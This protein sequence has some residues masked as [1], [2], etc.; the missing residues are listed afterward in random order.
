[1]SNFFD[2]VTKDAKALE[3]KL[4]GP[5]YP[6]Y[7]YVA[8]PKQVGITPEGSLSATATD[9]AGL[10]NY[11]E[12]L[13]TGKGKA[14]TGGGEP[15]GDK[16]FLK[17]GGQ[18]KDI[19]SGKLVDRYLY[20]NNQPD[21]SVPFITSGAG[22]QFTDFE[23]LVPGIIEDLDAMNPISIFRGFMEGNNPPCTEITMPTKTAKNVLGSSSFHVSNGDIQDLGPCDFPSKTNPVTK[24]SCKEAFVGSA[25]DKKDFKSI[26]IFLFGIVMLFIVQRLL[27]RN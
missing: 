2:E 25:L 4:L 12:L 10:I 14:N 6:Y 17:T 11:V 15:L 5:D 22:V 27:K 18:C 9:I 26:Y 1:M 20:I 21:G 23:G 19:Q 7:K 13:I 16:F 3:E 24:E 8:T